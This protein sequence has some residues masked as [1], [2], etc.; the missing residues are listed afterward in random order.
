[1]ISQ[2]AILFF[3]F[4][5]SV[6]LV[7]VAVFLLGNQLLLWVFLSELGKKKMKK[8]KLVRSSYFSFVLLTRNSASEILPCRN[9]WAVFRYKCDVSLRDP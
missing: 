6:E 1:M 2:G 5:Y 8:L 3:D 7:S 4:E 9:Q